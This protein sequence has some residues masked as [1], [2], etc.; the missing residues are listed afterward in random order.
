MVSSPPAKLM[1]KPGVIHGFLNNF[2][3][4]EDNECFQFTDISCAG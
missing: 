3:T 4:T 1:L 2:S